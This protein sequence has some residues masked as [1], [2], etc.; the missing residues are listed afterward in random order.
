[1]NFLILRIFYRRLTS[2]EQ[3]QV[4]DIYLEDGTWRQVRSAGQWACGL[5]VLRMHARRPRF[6]APSVVTSGAQL[7]A[8]ERARQIE[9]EG[10]D[11]SNDAYY[12]LDELALAAIVYA[13][14]EER[15]NDVYIPQG[16]VQHTSRSIRAVLWPWDPA[17]FKPGDRIRELTKAGALIAAEIDRLQQRESTDDT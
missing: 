16:V 6:L 13:L 3:L 4:G 17:W 10:F 5:Y 2:Q 12:M 7:I 9:E 11:A 1:M 8:D 15:R 14:P